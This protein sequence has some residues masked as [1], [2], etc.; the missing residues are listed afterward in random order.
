M[1]EDKITNLK[2]LDYHITVL[3]CVPISY[4]AKNTIYSNFEI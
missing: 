4:S 2:C 3:H 1:Q